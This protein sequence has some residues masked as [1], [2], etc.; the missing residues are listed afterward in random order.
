[1]HISRIELE[2][3]KSHRHST[4]DFAPGTTAITGENG[5]GKTTIIEA[6]AWVLFDLLEYKKEDFIRRGEKKGVAR[7]AFVSGL[8]EREYVVYRD[9]GTGYN[10]VDPRIGR[11]VADK[12]DEVFRFLWQHLGLEPGSDLRSLFRQAIGVPQGTFTAIFLE[13][14]VA[15]KTAFDRLLKVEEYR[16]AADKLRET[17]RFVDAGIADI[18]EGIARA[19]GELARAA[20][21]EEEYGAYQ[22]RTELLAAD[23]AASEAEIGQ[24]RHIVARLDEL[25]RIERALETV[26][27]D[28][29]HLQES[30]ET[31]RKAHAD[32][33]TLKPKVIEQEKLESELTGLRQRIADL[34]AAQKQA[35]DLDALIGRM[36]NSYK[37]NSAQLKEALE[38]SDRAGRV[39][40]LEK[41]DGELIREIAT[42]N[43]SLER[44]EKFQSEIKG[45]FCPVLSQKCLNLKPGETLEAFIATQFSELKARIVTLET[46]R[47]TVTADLKQARDAEKF[48]ALVDGLREREEHLKAEGQH[49]AGQRNELEERISG[50]AEC[51]RRSGEVE[52]ALH[53]LG[54]PRSRVRYLE[55]ETTRE[56]ELAEKQ[57]HLE[58]SLENLERDRNLL[59]E[60]L[61]TEKFIASGVFDRGGHAAERASIF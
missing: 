35:A 2:N 53:T 39:T 12:K 55:N 18:R 45:G 9:T 32:I 14:A 33:A 41:R 1:M 11:R 42:L 46:E 24:R 6:I 7:V 17:V 43:A 30:V 34:R 25:E 40:P 61:E 27:A 13:T 26:R 36:R 15:R 29:K 20:A 54:D 57:R 31:V 38:R 21:V 56:P 10:V 19:E 49:L 50:L 8:D 44:D 23:A 3:I 47:L 5:A 59:V 4:F 37:S 22:G 16:D 51:E 60:E 28:K 58:A 48:A 52:A